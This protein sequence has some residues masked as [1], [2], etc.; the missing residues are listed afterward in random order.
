MKRWIFN[1]ALCLCVCL[2]VAGLCGKAEAKYHRDQSF[3]DF[4]R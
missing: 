2:L 4:P 3:M 1:M